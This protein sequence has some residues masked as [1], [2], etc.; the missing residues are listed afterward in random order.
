MIDY[1]QIREQRDLMVEDYEKIYSLNK[2]NR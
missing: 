1:E 2:L